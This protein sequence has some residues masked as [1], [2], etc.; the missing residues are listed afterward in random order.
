MTLSWKA[1]K[2]AGLPL[3]QGL[4][5]V[6]ILSLVVALVAAVASVCGIATKG[7]VYPTKALM[8]MLLPDEILILYLG[9][10]VL[11]GSMWMT[12]KGQLLGLLCWSGSLFFLFYNYLAY[13]FAME[14]SPLILAY[15]AL[16]SMSGI[17]LIALLVRIDSGKVAARL[18]G[19]VGEKVSGA[20][21]A[22]MASFVLI[23]IIIVVGSAILNY[24]PLPDREM[25][26]YS[27]DF[28]VAPTW[29]IGGV[30]LWRRKDLGL[31]FGLGLL[32]QASL[33]FLALVF[34]LLLQPSFTGIRIVFS[35]LALAAALSLLGIV[36]LLLFAKGVSAKSHSHSPMDRPSLQSLARRRRD[37]RL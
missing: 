8:R 15:L 31:L 27:V 22:L 17:S 30:L 9:L 26:L 23:R 33:H 36:S 3:K 32:L 6:Y 12:R 35:D 7:L 10:P 37:G 18:R 16:A 4:G 13:C 24:A 21:L 29:I 14:Q 5:P 28:L 34:S 20:A 11:L 25:A 19:S 1:G 2:E